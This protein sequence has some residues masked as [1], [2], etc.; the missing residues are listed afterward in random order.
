MSGGITVKNDQDLDPSPDAAPKDQSSNRTKEEILSL[1][2]Q[3]MAR[4]GRR[5]TTLRMI[6]E[7]AGLS[8]A[9]ITNH[10]GTKDNLVRET[11]I[12]V[13]NQERRRLENQIARLSESVTDANSLSR[14]LW[15]ELSPGSENERILSLIWLQLQFETYRADHKNLDIFK[16]WYDQKF[17]FWKD[18]FTNQTDCQKRRARLCI[19]FLDAELLFFPDNGL[20]LFRPLLIAE[21]CTKFAEI[22]WQDS[23]KSTNFNTVFERFQREH[24]TKILEKISTQGN[25]QYSEIE[26]AILNTSLDIIAKQGV[27]RLTHRRIAK[28]AH[29]SLSSTTYY[30][31][32]IGD[33]LDQAFLLL[34][35]NIISE[36]SP[37]FFAGQNIDKTPKEMIDRTISINFK[38]DIT[39][40]TKIKAIQLL[41]FEV[42]RTSRF[43]SMISDITFSRG[44]LTQMSL[45]RMKISKLNT[46]TR[47]QA[48]I[49]DTIVTGLMPPQN[50][51]ETSVAEI[52][53]DL[54]WIFERLFQVDINQG[55]ADI[56]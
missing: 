21:R 51:L 9:A 38:S 40:R 36:V 13:M 32:S 12:Y 24:E 42:S 10:F 49:F 29:I 54:T 16:T 27:D 20:Q 19:A 1:T 34:Y 25:V 46:A 35:R 2:S 18:I 45:Q 43:K 7:Q 52:E 5:A 33:I 39:V 41:I 17:E 15:S 53:R 8:A 31:K 28:A 56:H 11:Y 4:H 22:L 30:F 47:F 6:A 37:Q 26:L 44:L 55:E 50:I 3:C 23:G 14:L 48:S